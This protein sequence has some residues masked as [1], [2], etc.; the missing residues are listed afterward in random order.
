MVLLDL[1]FGS[2]VINPVHRLHK[3]KC[4]L[5]RERVG[6]KQAGVL[7]NTRLKGRFLAA[8]CLEQVLE[9]AVPFL[10]L[11]ASS[12]RNA[13]N[14]GVHHI[15]EQRRG[16]RPG[17]HL[18]EDDI[19]PELAHIHPRERPDWEETISAMHAEMR[20]LHGNMP[21]PPVSGVGRLEPS[22]RKCLLRAGKREKRNNIHQANEY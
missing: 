7:L 6:G 20:P 1:L 2:S 13:G 21:K 19:V 22:Y 5:Q 16:L 18:E 12:P 11:R 4:P 14:A 8:L 10:S 3:L 9:G 17:R 15:S